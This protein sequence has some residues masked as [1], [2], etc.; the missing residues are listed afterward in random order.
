M[1]LVPP[2]ATFKESFLE[3]L[4][5]YKADDGHD[6]RS[7]RNREAPIRELEHDFDAYVLQEVAAAR[8]EGLPEGYVPET[9]LWL[10]DDGAFIG[11]VSI[12]HELT[13]RLRTVGGHIGYDI[14]PSMRGRGYGTA[15]LRLALPEARA[16][17][18]SRA[19]VTC[20]ATNEASRKIIE[21]NGGVLED[22]TIDP[23]TGMD[24]LRFWIDIP[25][26]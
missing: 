6:V 4:R 14:R 5:E 8:G 18:I 19:L 10:V 13:E 7:R 20:D 15:I 12:R 17:G 9:T 1:R 22:R 23:E 24:K 2:S 11:S 3:A 21:K 25:G 26:T 16:L